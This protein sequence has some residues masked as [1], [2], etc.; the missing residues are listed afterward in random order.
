MSDRLFND[1]D[2]AGKTIGRKLEDRVN[3]PL[4]FR[5]V[6]VKDGD[7]EVMLRTKGGRPELTVKKPEPKAPIT[8]CVKSPLTEIAFKYHATTAQTGYR[9]WYGEPDPVNPVTPAAPTYQYSSDGLLCIEARKLQKISFRDANNQPVDF[10]FAEQPVN[11][12]TPAVD[13]PAVSASAAAST[14][15]FKFIEGKYPDREWY[16]PER[17]DIGWA[18]TSPA[19]AVSFFIKR[20]KSIKFSVTDSLHAA[21]GAVLIK[22]RFAFKDTAPLPGTYPDTACANQNATEVSFPGREFYA[23]AT[24]GNMEKLTLRTGLAEP[25]GTSNIRLDFKK[26]GSFVAAVDPEGATGN[27]RPADKT[28]AIDLCEFAA[29]GNPYHGLVWLSGSATF[30]KD[31]SRTTQWPFSPAQPAWPVAIGS[32]PLLLDTRYYN[33]YGATTHE[34]ID[35]GHPEDGSMLKDAILTY[36]AWYIKDPDHAG[37]G[38]LDDN[39][40]LYKDPD[41]SVWVVLLTPIFNGLA[42][43]P[44]QTLTLDLILQRRYGVLGTNFD[45]TA[46][47]IGRALPSITVTIPGL[48]GVVLDYFNDG[49]RFRFSVG[50]SAT[51]VMC[52][53]Y[54]EAADLEESTPNVPM[55]GPATYGDGTSYVGTTPKH[56]LIG[57][58][59]GILLTFSGVG[60][61]VASTGVDIGDGVTADAKL[62]FAPL[63]ESRCYSYHGRTVPITGSLSSAVNLTYANAV[64]GGQSID[65]ISGGTY[66][67]SPVASTSTEFDAQAFTRL[68]IIYRD[69]EWV[70]VLGKL[71]HSQYGTTSTVQ[72]VVNGVASLAGAP[73]CSGP[74]LLGLGLA[75]TPAAY[76][77]V[78]L[79]KYDSRTAEIIIAGVTIASLKLIRKTDT[80]TSYTHTTHIAPIG[81]LAI[82]SVSTYPGTPAGYEGVPV[83]Q[84]NIGVIGNQPREALSNFASRYRYFQGMGNTPWAYCLNTHNRQLAQNGEDVLALDKLNKAGPT[85]VAKMICRDTV[86]DVPNDDLSFHYDAA[87]VWSYATKIG[88]AYD[89]RTKELITVPFGTVAYFI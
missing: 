36:G 64:C 55:F 75:L 41:G 57:I 26:P 69:G 9:R 23:S 83:E 20:V 24:D 49:R 27:T 40:V 45:N 29:F 89:Y 54:H 68:D 53:V 5:T 73:Y 25:Y 42:E 77:E 70:E 17:A 15:R 32:I 3:D 39:E 47:Y 76:G 81:L 21:L 82:S 62:M 59:A 52:M 22:W 51:D 18:F 7:N 88:W 10:L 63:T 35:N 86:I 31:S 61:V 1:R 72:N 13:L 6:I 34:G 87:S 50:P 4:G 85:A 80:T 33:V 37:W 8:T 11:P 66:P 44:L 79:T 48:N 38:Q 12:D 30:Y 28:K 74:N 46:N 71:T 56:K 67:V 84:L 19:T 58:Q 78:V 43:W 60:A 16:P 2:G 14:A 65:Y